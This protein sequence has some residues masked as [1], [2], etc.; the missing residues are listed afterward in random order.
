MTCYFRH[1]DDVFKKAQIEVTSENRQKIDRI[2]H[3]MVGA[4]YKDCPGVWR[5]VKKCL[6]EDEAGFVA[7][8]KTAWKRRN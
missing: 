3:D 7:K 2:I 6:A 4:K 8:L 1:L 5:E